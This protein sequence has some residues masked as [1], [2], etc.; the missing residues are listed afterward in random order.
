MWFNYV[1]E[2]AILANVL[3]QLI[4]VPICLITKRKWNPA[5]VFST[6]EC[7][8]HILLLLLH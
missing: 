4:K 6:G 3:A 1:L 2:S 8:V 7:R 5:L